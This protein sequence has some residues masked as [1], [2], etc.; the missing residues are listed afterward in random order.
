MLIQL[1]S[2][3]LPSHNTRLP[4]QMKSALHLGKS[5]RQIAREQGVDKSAVR[6]SV[7]SGKAAMRKYLKK[8]L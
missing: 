4:C 5:Y 3:L 6:H 8:F 1:S 7:K 2:Q